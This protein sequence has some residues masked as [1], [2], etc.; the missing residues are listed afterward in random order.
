LH[1]S[2]QVESGTNPTPHPSS[3]RC[4]CGHCPSRYICSCQ[5][6]EVLNKCAAL[7]STP[8]LQPSSSVAGV[9]SPPAAVTTTPTTDPC[10]ASCSNPQPWLSKPCKQQQ[11]A[12][13]SKV[14]VGLECVQRCECPRGMIRVPT[15]TGQSTMCAQLALVCPAGCRVGRYQWVPPTRRRLLT[16]CMACPK[17][18]FQAVQGAAVCYQCPSGKYQSGLAAA[19]CLQCPPS[20]PSSDGRG[21]CVSEVEATASAEA[22]ESHELSSKGG[23]A[24]A[25]GATG[26][27]GFSCPKGHVLKTHLA[28]V[29]PPKTIP[30]ALP[31]AKSA[32]SSGSGDLGATEFVVP[33]MNPMETCCAEPIEGKGCLRAEILD[34][35]LLWRWTQPPYLL[36]GGHRNTQPSAEKCRKQCLDSSE[37][38]LGTYFPADRSCW[39]STNSGGTGRKCEASPTMTGQHACISFR[40][41]PMPTLPPTP[42]RPTPPTPP[43]LIPTPQPTPKPTAHASSRSMAAHLGFE[44]ASIPVTHAPTALSTL[45]PTSPV[46]TPAHTSTDHTTCSAGHYVWNDQGRHLCMQCPPGKY[47]LGAPWVNEAT[48]TQCPKGKFQPHAGKALCT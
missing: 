48:C 20:R 35:S 39:L 16:S 5:P 41:M 2:S 14:G 37:C 34:T 15:A 21:H 1:T 11:L 17:G 12:V 46:A 26:C 25:N 23:A 13:A 43:T 18:K 9:P 38:S 29:C 7:R 33:Q 8:R 6:G 42:A 10:T 3:P 27:V 36:G 19:S 45:S 28:Q 24:S 44:I 4:R 32:T 22:T 30:M 40:K 47:S 31:K